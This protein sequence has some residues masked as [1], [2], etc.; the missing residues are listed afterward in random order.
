VLTVAA[1][2]FA[3]TAVT[4]TVEATALRHVPPT[5]LSGAEG[6]AWLAEESGY[7]LLTPAGSGPVLRVPLY[8]APRP[9][10]AL[11]LA[12]GALNFGKTARTTATLTLTGGAIAGGLLPTQTATLTAT[13]SLTGSKPPTRPTALAGLFA[14]QHRSP[15]Q[16][17]APDGS[18]AGDRY[19]HADLYAV[20]A[21]GPLPG[22]GAETLY[23]ALSTYAPWSSPHQVVFHVDFDTNLDG[24]ADWRLV[25]RD[26]AGWLTTN[27]RSDEFV[28]VL[29]DL[30]T[31]RATRQK[32]LN[33]Y[34]PDRYDTRLLDNEVMVLPVRLGDMGLASS[35]RQIRYRVTSYSED[36]SN[37][38]TLQ[39]A[40]DQTPWL[41]LDLAAPV[42]Q[43]EATPGKS[44]LLEAAPGGTVAF[45]F[46]RTSFAAMGVEGLMALLLH[47][48]TGRRVQLIPVAYEWPYRRY[49]PRVTN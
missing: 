46:E 9:V 30:T 42:F 11:Q 15:P 22:D 39:L 12:P 26:A 5:G 10:A 19:A 25:N 47:N 48:P 4:L 36:I 13:E 3:H 21:A 31:E 16:S 38:T 18:F 41:T 6:R 27:Q 24:V 35:V 20:G 49:L 40:I 33:S 43:V 17:K 37:A 1:G 23:I 44:P 29:V 7:L 32:N 8:A 45:T 2:D 28:S 14:L 34:A